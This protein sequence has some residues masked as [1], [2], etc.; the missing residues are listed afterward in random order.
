M[1]SANSC[2]DANNSEFSAAEGRTLA[3]KRSPSSGL[4]T[5]N[6]VSVVLVINHGFDLGM[7][8]RESQ[9][10]KPS[11][12]G[13]IG[14]PLGE[15]D[16]ARSL[17][18]RYVER[19]VTPGTADIGETDGCGQRR[20]HYTTQIEDAKGRDAVPVYPLGSQPGNRQICGEHFRRQAEVENKKFRKR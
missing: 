17:F 14:L 2:G 8:R 15:E 20:N 12:K 5:R 11:A 3:V 16:G 19:G 1:K 7:R 9:C 18:T 6:S 4:S 13:R 10:G